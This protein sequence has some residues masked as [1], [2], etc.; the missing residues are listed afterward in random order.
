MRLQGLALRETP[1]SIPELL[2]DIPGLKD[3]QN[4]NPWRLRWKH[5][6]WRLNGPAARP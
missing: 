4:T 3:S 1:E 2:E 5:R 6:Q